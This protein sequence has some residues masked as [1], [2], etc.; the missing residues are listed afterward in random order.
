MKLAKTLPT[1]YF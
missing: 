1:E